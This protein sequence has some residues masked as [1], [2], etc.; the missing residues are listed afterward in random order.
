M[1]QWNK[2][3]QLIHETARKKVN[4]FVS[5][6]DPIETLFYIAKR[7]H[8]AHRNHPNNLDPRYDVPIVNLLFN[9]AI[10]Q[11]SKGT[12]KPTNKDIEKLEDSLI[13]YCNHFDVRLSKD[14]SFFRSSQV[15]YI[16][17]LQNPEMYPFQFERKLN[18]LF[19]NINEDFLCEF[20]FSPLSAFCFSTTINQIYIESF[21]NNNN[22]KILFSEKDVE[23]FINPPKEKL[24]IFRK[25]LKSY[26]KLL[27]IKINSRK[28]DY[29]S[30]LDEDLSWKKPF[31]KT[32]KGYL[33]VCLIQ[34]QYGIFT[35]LEE[36]IKSHQEINKTLWEKYRKVKSKY[37]ENLAYESFKRVFGNK[38]YK[39]LKYKYNGSEYEID[40]LV[41][42]DNKII[43]AEVKSGSIRLDSKT[44]NKIKLEK[45]LKTVLKKS[46]EQTK[47]AS[48]YILSENHPYFYNGKIKV[49]LEKTK[50]NL[51]IFPICIGME[52]LGSVT[53]NLRIAQL[54]NFFEKNQYPWAVNVQDLEVISNHISYCSLF[55]HYIKSRLES[56]KN[57][58]TIINASD[59]LSYFGAY[60][61]NPQ[62][63]FH[64]NNE[65]HMVNFDPSFNK[66][67]DDYY[68]GSEKE[69]PKV[70]LDSRLER[71]IREWE[72]LYSKGVIQGGQSDIACW[73]LSLNS[74]EL[75]N[76]FDMIES[77]IKKTKKDKKRHTFSFCCE[78]FCFVFISQYGKDKLIENIS[79][80]GLMKKYE[81]QKNRLLGLG[82]DVDPQD[83]WLINEAF[84]CDI[85]HRKDPEMDGILNEWKKNR[86]GFS[87]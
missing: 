6:Y 64:F 70:N 44:G 48:E 10:N 62:G 57:N 79:N 84:I 26:L 74:K 72:F 45:D 16:I 36:L 50:P 49:N 43:I 33:G 24:D 75:K 39:N 5:K 28:K 13:H 85:P 81:F 67:L 66:I 82:T 87:Q 78:Q 86:G 55:I 52:N 58:T 40:V 9:I 21:Q 47:K 80:Y 76:T 42:Y 14:H 25:E 51:E 12:E 41:E 4:I 53:Q 63:G 3:R 1:N 11:T 65:V 2:Q 31:I 22:K 56:Q 34:N 71:F 32:E 7:H 17:N 20:G 8:L 18:F 38:V 27:S 60:L 30:L 35:Q 46:Y 69:K 23:N 59:E 73:L 15:Q 37:A 61:Q 77:C 54:D 83:Q 29:E 19:P 68:T